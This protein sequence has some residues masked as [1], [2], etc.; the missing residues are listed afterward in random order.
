MTDAH[1]TLT[2]GVDTALSRID[3]VIA[4]ARPAR[5]A[6]KLSLDT[7]GFTLEPQKT[8]LK[9][10]EFFDTQ[11][12]IVERLY[13]TEMKRSIKKATGCDEVLILEHIV[14]DAGAADAR[15][16]KN[17]FASG[18]NGINGY[19][20]VVHTDF[21]A[22]RAH[23][24]ARSQGGGRKQMNSSQRDRQRFMIVNT[25]RNISD[26]HLIYNNT[27]ALCDG[28]TVRDV[29]PC[30][31]QHPN[32]KRSEQYRLSAASADEHRWFYFPYLH[33]DELLIFKQYDSDPNARVRYCFHTA[34]NDPTISTDAPARQSIEVRAV[35]LFNDALTAPP[36]LVR[37]L[38][39]EC[40]EA[41]MSE[42]AVSGSGRA[43]AGVLS[44]NR[45][46]PALREV[47]CAQG[48]R[49]AKS[50]G[51]VPVDLDFHERAM[52]EGHRA[53]GRNDEDEDAQMVQALAASQMA[54]E[55]D[56]AMKEA[57]AASLHIQ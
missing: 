27:L 3:T 37:N 43:A 29:L 50:Q 51:L 32:G 2:Y 10:Q 12:G 25:W 7:H 24:L 44:S 56:K 49:K 30:D 19:A 45:G 23:D 4:D 18:G 14:R 35:A 33:K 38:S 52:I 48:K 22:D 6:K 46:V 17:P 53:A 47:Q 31:V 34:F 9:T 21:R 26:E 55:E 20:G 11:T 42:R 5:E 39:D 16:T 41:R 28:K 54:A 15:G 57:L 1:T 36:P 40:Y 8:G 13:Y